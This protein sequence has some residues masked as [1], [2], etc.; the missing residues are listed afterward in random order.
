[1]PVL[2]PR[3][4]PQAWLRPWRA[5]RAARPPRLAVERA[6]YVD[7]GGRTILLTFAYGAPW[8][9]E[10]GAGWQQHVWR[11]RPC[12]FLHF[13]V[14][15]RVRGRPLPT[16]GG[17]RVVLAGRQGVYLT[18]LGY[19]PRCR[20]EERAAFWCNHAVFVWRERGVQYAA[21]LHLFGASGTRILLGRLVAEL[22]PVP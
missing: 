10:S 16:A 17:H 1:V 20:N 12:C 8:E 3:R 9:P 6:D 14:I 13:E 11:N 5:P 18:A 2:C 19:A 22:A 21:T 7:R 4:V 15:T